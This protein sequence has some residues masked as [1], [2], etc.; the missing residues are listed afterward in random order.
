MRVRW[1]G[2]SAFLLDG[3]ARVFID[4]FGPMPGLAERGRRFDYPPIAGI[5][6]DLLLVTH[7]HPDHNAVEAVGGTP[8]VL[9]S[10]AGT[11]AVT[12]VGEVVGVASEHD[13][14][15]GTLRGHNVM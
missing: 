12:P 10:L 4:P 9:R 13:P 1:F 3:P 11:F 2:Q 7:D 5:A 6:A 15:A 8:H 14:E